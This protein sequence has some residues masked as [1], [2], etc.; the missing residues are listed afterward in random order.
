MVTEI[1]VN[2]GSGNDLL[3]NGTKPLPEPMLTYHQWG[4]VAFTW[5]QFHSWSAEAAILYNESENYTLNVTATS[6]GSVS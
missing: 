1:W 3:P 2:I 5:E 4:S 6:Q